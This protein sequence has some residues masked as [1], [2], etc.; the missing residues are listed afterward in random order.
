MPKFAV[1][2]T[3][4]PRKRNR[5]AENFSRIRSI[6]SVAPSLF[7][8]VRTIRNSSPPMRPQMSA[9]LVLVLRISANP[10]RTTSPASC[11]YVSFTDLKL[12][13]SAITAHKGKSCLAAALSSRPAQSSMPRRLSKPVIASVRA[14][15][16]NTF[17]QSGQNWGLPKVVRTLN[18]PLFESAGTEQAKKPWA[19]R[20][21]QR[22]LLARPAPTPGYHIRKRSR[23]R[24]DRAR[25][26]CALR[27]GD[28]RQPRLL[29]A[30][31]PRFRLKII[32]LL[33]NKT[34]CTP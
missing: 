7:V 31:I 4:W 28:S 13:I 26:T 9:D 5:C 20:P 19:Q 6:A 22:E 24:R 25:P 29:D 18:C 15:S 10:L 27:P 8:R 16:S 17:L 30:F 12:S 23:L 33:L 1:T 14:N 3:S 32:G 2:T 11:P 21:P 34:C